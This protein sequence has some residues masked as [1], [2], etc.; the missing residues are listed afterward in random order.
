MCIWFGITFPFYGE[1]IRKPSSVSQ[2]TFRHFEIVKCFLLFLLVL[3]ASQMRNVANFLGKGSSTVATDISFTF[4]WLKK[5]KLSKMM[6]AYVGVCGRQGGGKAMPSI[7]FDW[8]ALKMEHISSFYA[9][10]KCISSSI[11][12]SVLIAAC[13][14]KHFS[15]SM[16]VAALFLSGKFRLP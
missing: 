9:T 3:I 11:T 4:E 10:P 13:K 1:N 6:W 7:H 2:I 12:Y 15:S 14:K 5:I 16:F 8:F